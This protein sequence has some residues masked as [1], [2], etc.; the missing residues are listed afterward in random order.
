MQFKG[1]MPVFEDWVRKPSSYSEQWYF[2]LFFFHPTISVAEKSGENVSIKA[3]YYEGGINWRP[4]LCIEV[5]CNSVQF[6]IFEAEQQ[7][8]APL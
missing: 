5:F 6:N 4:K 8:F 3:A 7:I 1:Y 2:L